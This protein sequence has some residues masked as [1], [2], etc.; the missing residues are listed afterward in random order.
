MDRRTFLTTTAASAAVMAIASPAAAFEVERSEA[1]WRKLLTKTQ[2]KVMR[3]NGTERAGSSPL[4]KNWA[5]GTYH[6]R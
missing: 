2:F 4:D 1:E 5:A 3:Q 6:C